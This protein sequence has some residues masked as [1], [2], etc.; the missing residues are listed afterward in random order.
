MFFRY[1]PGPQI[2]QKRAKEFESGRPLPDDDPVPLNRMNFS[3]SELARLSSKKLVPNVC[4]RAQEYETRVEPRRDP[5]GTST[6]SGQSVFK[7]IQRD[8]RSLDS[9]GILLFDEHFFRIYKKYKIAKCTL[10]KL[11]FINKRQ[12]ILYC[13]T[14]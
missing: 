12:I 13:P 4:E 7:R 5:S 10:L 11:F 2:V 3:R 14:I 8:S 9:S 1:P 6:S